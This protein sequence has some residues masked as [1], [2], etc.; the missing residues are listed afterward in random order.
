SAS[1]WRKRNVS[2]LATVQACS[3]GHSL[4]LKTRWSEDR[5]VKVKTSLKRAG[6]TGRKRRK[7]DRAVLGFEQH[8]IG[9]LVAHQHLL[10]AGRTQR[11]HG[12]PAIRELFQQDFR[13]LGDRTGQEDAV[14]GALLG[15]P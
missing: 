13:R 6:A 4:L 2:G 3:S 1:Q 5:R 10:L 12:D 9:P 8:V 11:N 15:K 14:E 7:P